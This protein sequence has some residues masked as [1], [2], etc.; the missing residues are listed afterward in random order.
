[1]PGDDSAPAWLSP[2]D[3]LELCSGQVDVWRAYLRIRS[4]SLEWLKSTLSEDEAA[5]AERFHFNVDR[6]RFIAAHGC[7][8]DILGR[9]LRCEPARLRFSAGAFGKPA[10]RMD[11]GRPKIEF[12]LAH[13]GDHALIAVAQER[14]VGVDVERIRQGISAEELA[15]RYFSGSEV[16]QLMA[17]QPEQ[18]QVGFFNGWA[19][20][21]AYI[22]AHGLGLSLPLDSFDVSL[23]PQ[24]PALLLATRPDPEEAAR[25]TLYNLHAD[26]DYA[27]ALVAEGRVDAINLWKWNLEES[28]RGT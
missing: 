11:T 19:R 13:S 25:W 6:E 12:N 14:K 8:R 15:G 5:R 20:K 26:S 27:A 23:D 17:L 21:E 1:M 10:L 4:D 3:D 16:S 28:D 22:K 18:R 7:L 9:Y 24:R 2:P